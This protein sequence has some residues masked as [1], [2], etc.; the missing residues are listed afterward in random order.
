MITLE[1]RIT[2]SDYESWEHSTKGSVAWISYSHM[3][4]EKSLDFD[5]ETKSW[6]VHFPG[7]GLTSR[8]AKNLDEI[9]TWFKRWA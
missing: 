2:G 8:P 1:K 9:R 5:T 7:P 6:Q 3:D 4:S